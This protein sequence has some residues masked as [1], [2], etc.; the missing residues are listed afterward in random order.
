[1]VFQDLRGKGSGANGTGNKAVKPRILASN[2][3][4]LA[5]CPCVSKPCIYTGTSWLSPS[6]STSVVHRC[7]PGSRTNSY[8]RGALGYPLHLHGLILQDAAALRT[9]ISCDTSELPW[10]FLLGTGTFP[11]PQAFLCWFAIPQLQ[12]GSC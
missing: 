8:R 9:G 12:D 2:G 1:M 11:A 6:L 5:V 7:I 3:T 10:L 4:E